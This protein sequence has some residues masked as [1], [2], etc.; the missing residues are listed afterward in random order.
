MIEV[1]AGPALPHPE[2]TPPPS[3][4]EAGEGGALSRAL[5]GLR[6]VRDFFATLIST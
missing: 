2:G 4:G 1:V 6:S 5:S 3:S